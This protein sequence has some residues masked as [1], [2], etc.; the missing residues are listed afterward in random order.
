MNLLQVICFKI[1]QFVFDL[2][3][4]CEGLTFT[5][6]SSVF[7]SFGPFVLRDGDDDFVF[8]LP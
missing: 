1:N 3:Q 8:H 2:T 7:L 6:Y 5:W 4:R